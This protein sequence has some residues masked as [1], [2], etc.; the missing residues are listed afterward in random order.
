METHRRIRKAAA[1]Y[2][3]TG[4]VRTCLQAPVHGRGARRCACTGSAHA[5]CAHLSP[6]R[7][8]AFHGVQTVGRRASALCCL[9]IH[10]GSQMGARC[11]DLA[12]A[13]VQHSALYIRIA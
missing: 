2:M 4:Y 10:L 13:V 8:G 6:H 9:C 12:A 11:C 3:T 1:G 5:S 7:F